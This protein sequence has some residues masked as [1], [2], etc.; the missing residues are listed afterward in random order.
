[1]PVGALVKSVEGSLYVGQLGG[2]P[3]EEA[4]LATFG[5][6]RGFFGFGNVHLVDRIESTRRTLDKVRR[7]A[8]PPSRSPPN[9][10]APSAVQAMEPWNGNPKLK[11]PPSDATSQ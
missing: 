5:C 8:A 10:L 6:P 7:A 3:V 4:E 1:V 2:Y 11:I 9:E